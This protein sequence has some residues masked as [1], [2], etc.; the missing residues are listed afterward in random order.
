[1]KGSK[2][3]RGLSWTLFVSNG[4]DVSGKRL[5][6][7]K[8]L[9]PVYDEKKGKLVS[10]S[11]AEA[12]E[13]LRKFIVE[14]TGPGYAGRKTVKEYLEYWYKTFID[15]PEVPENMKAYKPKTK[16][17]Y[18]MN[19][20]VYL[21]PEFGHLLLRDLT[22][23]HIKRGFNNLAA[24]HSNLKKISIEGA[25]RVLRTALESAVGTYIEANP[26]KFKIAKPPKTTKREILNSHRVWDLDEAVKFLESVQDKWLKAAAY[27][28]HKRL[29]LYAIYLTALLQGMRKGEIIGLTWDRVDF[30][31]KVI[32]IEEQIS[33]GATGDV[34]TDSSYRHLRMTNLVMNALKQVQHYQELAIKKV[35]EDCWGKLNLVFTFDG[36]P[37][38]GRSLNRWYFKRDIGDAG[39]PM[40]RFH[41][42]RGSTAT[43][44]YELGEGDKIQ[45]ILGHASQAVADEH[46]IHKK[47]KDQ[48][49]AMNKLEQIFREK[50]QTF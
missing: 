11:D 5:R 21:I 23:H 6:E 25:F 39:V 37:L 14:V 26:A 28:E 4:S 42:L 50:L 41:D 27:E 18:K 48:D 32:K 40:I 49:S 33:E 1:L 10:L 12:D 13:E 29:T 47:V 8:T 36:K 34:K 44:L 38:D 30:E 3:K 45:S 43:L 20:E 16:E 19:M 24:K 9:P 46:Y 15:P 17:W 31:N 22:A 35:G 2:Y 7:T